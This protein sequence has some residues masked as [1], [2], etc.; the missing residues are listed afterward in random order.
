MK[1]SCAAV[2]RNDLSLVRAW[3][4]LD[5]FRCGAFINNAQLG[6]FTRLNRGFSTYAPAAG[7]VDRLIGIFLEWLEADPKQPFFAYL[8][9]LEAHWPYK[10]RRRHVAM[11]GG[12]R[13][14]NHFRDFSARD[15][16][17]LRRE[18]SHGGATLSDEQLV[19]MVQMYDGAIRRL[20]GKLKIILAM[21]KEFGIRDETSIIVTAD[22]GE[23][24]LDHGAIGHGQTVYN[25]LT[26]VPLVASIPGHDGCDR[27]PE[28][29]GHAD[30]A[31]TALGI[32]G[33][34]DAVPGKDLTAS[35]RSDR[36]VF[37]ELLVG[38]RYAQCM[39]TDRWTLHRQYKFRPENGELAR[40]VSPRKL[41]DE[42]P[43]DMG[44]ELFD[45]RTDLREQNDLSS[46][47]AFEA[48][49]RKL[50]EELDRWWCEAAAD[51][52]SGSDIEVDEELQERIRALGYVD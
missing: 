27:R 29:V 7:K 10:P 39:R 49:R 24:F 38:R 33:I 42:C 3:S 6:E 12:D 5:G 9:L 16:G 37:S 19:Q 4:G 26:H 35:A 18:V 46:D 13:D 25:E 2:A 8:H 44:V 31:A 48:D 22:H 50:I 52:S 45:A 51:S 30:L 14:T 1:R 43:H 23:E 41:V 15:F 36:P 17:K 28:P 21:L 34:A 40:K 11:F 47:P 20:D 32:A